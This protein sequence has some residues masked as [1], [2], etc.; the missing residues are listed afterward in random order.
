MKKKLYFLMIILALALATLACGLVSNSDEPAAPAEDEV[1]PMP[2]DSGILFSDDFSNP[3]S[4]WDQVNSDEGITDYDNGVY[5]I[6]VNTDNTDVWANPGLNFT[7]TI[8]EV[9]TT[10]AG[11]PDDNDFGVICRYQDTQNFYFFII[12]S[13]GFYGIG[14]VQ[15]GEQ[16]VLGED[17]QLLPGDAINQ[18]NTTNIIRAD[19][20]GNTLTLYVNGTQLASVQDD[21]FASGDVGLLAGTYDEIG[22]DIHFDN[23]IV[24]AP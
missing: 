12:S 20:V 15:D 21:T 6:F 16:S 19:C 10:K 9:E 22:T 3:Y 13:D 11:G 1:A 8:I 18:G 7:D 4:G 24:R 17:E 2:A 23:F 5:R 14:I